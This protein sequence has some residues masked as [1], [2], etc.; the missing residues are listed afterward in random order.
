MAT[1]SA[2]A[3][4]S[5]DDILAQLSLRDRLLF[6]QVVYELGCSDWGAIAGLL[7]KHP[8]IQRP[9]G[10]FTAQT[11][12]S[13]YVALMSDINVDFDSGIS[14]EAKTPKAKINL[15]LAQKF[16]KDRVAELKDQI[17]QNEEKF[18]AIVREVEEIKAGK[19]DDR[20]LAEEAK[21]QATVDDKKKKSKAGSSAN[22]LRRSTRSGTRISEPPTAPETPTSPT[23][24]DNAVT[25]PPISE[26]VTEDATTNSDTAPSE[27]Q[28]LPAD[29]DSDAVHGATAIAS[30]SRIHSIAQGKR[31]LTLESAGTEP[32]SQP[33]PSS[34]LTE[35][36][37]DAAQAAIPAEDVEME[38]VEVSTP[39][40][41]PDGDADTEP[42]ASPTVERRVTRRQTNARN[43][44]GKAAEPTTTRS[45]TASKSREATAATVEDDSAPP[46]A[47]KA[48]QVNEKGAIPRTAT[49]STAASSKKFQGVITMLHGQICT[50]RNGNL[51]HNPV[52][53]SEAEGYFDIVK[54]P[55][56]LKTIKTKIKDGSIKDS[57]EFQRDILLMFANAKMYNRPD[58]EIARMSDEMLVDALRQI[59]E[60]RQTEQFRVPD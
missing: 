34:E 47:P 59:E 43:N 52:K 4:P 2:R 50:H 7:A 46:A 26:E 55:M 33:E 28:A 19:W 1:R 49:T 22:N 21:K 3:A 17:L 11:C 42:P 40:I 25:E 48:P 56:D 32:A 14:L 30:G 8:L 57:L 58:S 29:D 31:K 51:F 35:L 54:R 53:E 9:K 12:N 13:I 39:K 38:S 20:L 37:Q 6:A 18:K 44:K 24:P 10:F 60:F 5:I 36:S 23:Q 16:Y 45:R 27:A 41:E 15:K